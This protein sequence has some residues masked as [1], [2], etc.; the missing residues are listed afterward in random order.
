MTKF[1]VFSMQFS[2]L[3]GLYLD[4][5]EKKG[6]SRQEVDRLLCR[7]CG[8][9][10]RRLEQLKNDG[11]TL[12]EFASKITPAPWTDRVGGSICGVK[13]ESID[14]P[15]MKILR[16]LDKVIDELAKGKSVEKIINR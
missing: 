9:E 4:K 6:R 13:I 8:I 15:A 14:N 10:P 3:Y 2:R 5:A 12:G 16:R 7:F 11:L 1:D